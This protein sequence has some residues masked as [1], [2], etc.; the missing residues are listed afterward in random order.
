MSQTWEGLGAVGAMTI[1]YIWLQVG[2]RYL[3][4]PETERAPTPKYLREVAV[5]ADRLGYYGAL[6]PTGAHC[7][8]AWITAASIAPLSTGSSSWWR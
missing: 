5:A 7:V 3:N 6:L 1:V 4:S 8:D 2:I